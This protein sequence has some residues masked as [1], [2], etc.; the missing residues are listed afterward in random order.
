MKPFL[1]GL[2]TLALIGC[3]ETK[4]DKKKTLE[5]RIPGPQGHGHVKKGADGKALVDPEAKVDT[6]PPV[7]Q[8]VVENAS[9][10]DPATDPEGSNAG[11]TTRQS[12]PV[13]LTS[14][15]AG[16]VEAKPIIRPKR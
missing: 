15:S 1:F 14:P 2:V 4:P 13:S 12:P 3:G 7:G 10:P 9:A 16:T 8:Q 6:A 5:D 11:N